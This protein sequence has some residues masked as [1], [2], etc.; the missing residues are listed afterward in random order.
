M[1]RTS[2]PCWAYNVILYFRT[3]FFFELG[4]KNSTIPSNRSDFFSNSPSDREDFRLT[5]DGRRT[6][7]GMGG[8]TPTPVVC[9]TSVCFR[10]SRST[11]TDSEHRRLAGGLDVTGRGFGCVLWSCGTTMFWEGG[12]LNARSNSS[13]N[14]SL[15][16]VVFHDMI[17]LCVSRH[18]GGKQCEVEECL[19][20]SSARADPQF[21]ISRHPIF[22]LL[23]L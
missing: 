14:R 2:A 13:K 10:E 8:P 1:S 7:F 17:V 11:H 3:P 9:L 5:P 22:R 18:V 23:T 4:I 16:D 20:S 19:G 21:T 15:S 6:A 12:V